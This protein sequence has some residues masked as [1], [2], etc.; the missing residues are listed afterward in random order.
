MLRRLFPARLD[1]AGYR[2]STAA[3]W[4]F[5]VFLLLRAILGLNGAINTRTIAAADGIRLEGLGDGAVETILLLLRNLSLAQLPLVTIGAVVLWRWRSMVPFLFLVLLAEQVA[6][7]LV[8]LANPIPRT[9]AAGAWITLGLLALLFAGFV[10]SLWD[11]GAPVES[12]RGVSADR[13]EA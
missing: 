2:G 11:R 10:L 4:L 12:S 7:R 3:L 5:A 1:N 9:D 6:R 8:A 13:W